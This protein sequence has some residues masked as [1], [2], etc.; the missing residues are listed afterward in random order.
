MIIVFV[1]TQ[2]EICLTSN[3]KSLSV[4]SLD[5]HHFGM[6]S[7]YIFF[8]L[9]HFFFPLNK[10]FKIPLCVCAADLYNSEHP[11]ILC[12]DD[13]GVFSTSVSGEYILASTKFGM[14]IFI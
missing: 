2:V 13:S 5:V 8:F 14:S 3:I 1:Y 4:S 9:S 11:L 6:P 12:T 10:Y 7:T